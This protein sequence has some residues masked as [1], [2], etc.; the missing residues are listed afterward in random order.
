LI[1]PA[2]EYL[3]GRLLVREQT[4]VRAQGKAVGLGALEAEVVKRRVQDGGRTAAE[5]G[6]KRTKALTI[7][8][9]E[10]LFR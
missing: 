9:S 2:G 4:R 1:E 10:S 5:C 8:F 3:G 7:G 6:D